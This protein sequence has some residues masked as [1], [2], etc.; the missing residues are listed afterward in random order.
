[1][2]LIRRT[3]RPQRTRIYASAPRIAAASPRDGARP[4][5]KSLSWQATGGRGNCAWGAVGVTKVFLT[6]LIRL[7]LNM[8]ILVVE[9]EAK[10]ASFIR[11]ALEE[12]SYAV[13]LCDDG[14]KGLEL[15]E[16]GSYDLIILDLMLPGLS[17]LDV[18]H[19]LR[20]KKIHTPVLILTARAQLNQ[21]VK[22]L[23]CGRR[24]LSDQAIRHRRTLGAHTRTVASRKQASHP[25][26]SKS[27]TS[28]SIRPLAR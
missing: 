25:V 18:L 3:V 11:Q 13:D 16:F 10:V 23:G 27:K 17:G 19:K 14:A 22:G 8:R 20:S 7:E 21:K 26:S 24:R 2:L 6:I 28:S 5:E 12:E 4:R 9:D 1:M 15:A